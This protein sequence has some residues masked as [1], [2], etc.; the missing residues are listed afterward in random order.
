[1]QVGLALISVGVVPQRLFACVVELEA[2]ATNAVLFPHFYQTHG[3]FWGEGDLASQLRLIELL[4]CVKREVTG[5]DYKGF[6]PPAQQRIDPA[7]L[8][9]FARVHEAYFFIGVWVSL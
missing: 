1:M 8:C 6:L 4:G 7:G 9:C 2:H 3:L 5:S